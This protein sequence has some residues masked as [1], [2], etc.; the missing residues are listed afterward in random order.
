LVT[1]PI[2]QLR[3]GQKEPIKN[4]FQSSFVKVRMFTGDHVQT[5]IAVAKQS[6]IIT[7][8]DIEAAGGDMSKIA[9]HAD[10]LRDFF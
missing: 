3:F 2:C 6:C 10:L 8:S 7:D 9:M 1:Q 5:A 4:Q